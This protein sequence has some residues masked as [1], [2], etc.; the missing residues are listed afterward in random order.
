M[1]FWRGARGVGLPFPGLTPKP[2]QGTTEPLWIVD[3]LQRLSALAWPLLHRS[4][5][6]AA[7]DPA[8]VWFDL[9]RA[10]F[11]CSDRAEEVPAPWLPLSQLLSSESLILWLRDSLIDPG[12]VQ[13]ALDASKQVGTY[14]VPV[15]VIEGSDEAI[16]RSVFVRL[17]TAGVF[18]RETEVLNALHVSGGE[19]D[20]L[21]VLSDVCRETR[22]GILEEA[23]RLRCLRVVAG[24]LLD[25]LPRPELDSYEDVL[26]PTSV[27]LSA[28][29]AF[30]RTEGHIPHLRLMPYRLP[31]VILTS[32]FHRHPYPGP[33]TRR[34]LRRWLWRGII[35][36]KNWDTNASQLRV[37]S[38]II[39]SDE[40]ASV[41]RLLADAGPV[42][43]A[44][45][46][47]FCRL[48]AQSGRSFNSAEIK[49]RA[50]LQASL[51]P[52]HVETDELIDVS[53]LVDEAGP[54]ALLRV[55]E[56][57]QDSVLHPYLDE[58]LSALDSASAEVRASHLWGHSSEG[59]AN[60]TE[61]LT[62]YFRDRLMSLCEPG[63]PDISELSQMFADLGEE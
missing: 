22:M 61:L 18:L 57:R 31:V 50:A 41:R 34:L 20:P 15:V 54:N 48:M 14:Q 10:C 3:G 32:F 21:Q 16:A 27:A 38:T 44:T 25:T 30:L 12:L 29:L 11:V 13:T 47:D 17:N 26:P 62:R 58:P 56:A 40:S 24:E 23:W 59:E 43:T 7:D 1:V 51:A 53:L 5:G 46:D 37:V 60:R 35:N 28:V 52:R 55:D 6:K 63:M 36:L 4:S 42:D 19:R 2:P 49:V 33:Q 9:E 8:N 45:I 39:D